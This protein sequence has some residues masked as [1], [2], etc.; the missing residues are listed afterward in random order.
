MINNI[1]QHSWK[2]DFSIEVK[3]IT[4]NQI[5]YKEN[6]CVEANLEN[7]K[8]SRVKLTLSVVFKLRISIYLISARNVLQCNWTSYTEDQLLV[9]FYPFTELKTL[10]SKASPLPG[11]DPR[12]IKVWVAFSWILLQEKE[13]KVTAVPTLLNTTLSQSAITCNIKCSILGKLSW[14][15]F[16]KW[17]LICSSECE[18]WRWGTTTI[19]WMVDLYG[20]F[21]QLARKWQCSL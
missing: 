12:K 10:W 3:R 5:S 13:K 21:F 6:L 1:S 15:P 17:C 19:L 14:A 16:H 18:R 8:F 2:S 20:G 9:T 11:I 4:Q 7:G